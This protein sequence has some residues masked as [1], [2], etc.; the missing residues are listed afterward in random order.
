MRIGTWKVPA[1]KKVASLNLQ[2]NESGECEFSSEDASDVDSVILHRVAGILR[3]A[4][5][6]I[7]CQASHYAPSGDLNVQKCKNF[8][9]ETLYDFIAW[10]T[11]KECFD[12]VTCCGSS[13]ADMKVLGICHSII[14]RSC[15]TPTPITFG[16]GVQ[17]HHDHG[18]RELIEVLSTVG[19]SIT[20]DD[21]RKFLTSIALDQLP[22]PSEVQIPRRISQFDSKNIDSIVDVAIDN[23]D[24]NEETIDGKRTTHAMAIVLYQRSPVSRELSSIP[25]TKQKSLDT[26]QYKEQQIQVYRKPAKKPEPNV[27]YQVENE[28]DSNP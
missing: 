2:I 16:L 1:L 23:F 4:M 27:T 22:E 25:C 17:M 28:T 18:S 19:H 12:N 9:P 21:V 11:S 8:V 5:S 24:Q 20:Y 15:K 10:C 13:D 6:G 3:S 14:S 7:T 26:A